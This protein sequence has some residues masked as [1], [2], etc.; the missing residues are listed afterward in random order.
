M[1]HKH[2]K[3]EI[4]QNTH[5]SFPET[6]FGTPPCEYNTVSVSKTTFAVPKSFS[7]FLYIT[8]LQ[9]TD[10]VHKTYPQICCIISF[11]F[12]THRLIAHLNCKLHSTNTLQSAK[13]YTILSMLV[14]SFHTIHLL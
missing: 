7:Q 11:H 5:H 14:Q 10:F 3:L 12:S 8:S 13:L 9:D 1:P 4:K 6:D 2:P